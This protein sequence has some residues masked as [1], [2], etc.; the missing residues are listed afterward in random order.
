MS[1]SFVVKVSGN[2]RPIFG[3][4]NK[5]VGFFSIIS[6]SSKYLKNA[7]IPEIT[8]AWVRGLV[9]ASLIQATKSFKCWRTTASGATSRF[10]SRKNVV[11][12]VMSLM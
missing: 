1:I 12:L 3:A 9:P 2:F 4:S 8:R 10:F 6:S 7:L 5:A 11:S